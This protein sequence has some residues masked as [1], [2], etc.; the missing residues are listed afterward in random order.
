MADTDAADAALAAAGDAAAYERLYQRHVARVFSLAR[1]MIGAEEA[2]DVTQDVFIR[3]WRKIGLFRGDAQFG[4]WL[5]RLALNVILGKRTTVVKYRDRH[6]SAD[7]ADLQFAGRRDRVDLKMDMDRAID[8]LPG[9]ARQ[10][11]VLHDV[12]GYTHEEIA[13]MLDVTAGTSKSQL[14]RA[15]MTLRQHLA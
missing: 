6:E 2:E 7:G 10:V 11:F 12:E 8:L 5:Y 14:H 1:R 15:R 3:A 9:G 4:T 13:G